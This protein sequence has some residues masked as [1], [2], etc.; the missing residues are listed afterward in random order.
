MSEEL[1]GVDVIVA[2]R[3]RTRNTF[4]PSVTRLNNGELICVF[5]YSPGHVHPRG[6]IALVR[7]DDDG[8][9]WTLPEIIIDTPYDDRDPHIVQLKDGRIILSWFTTYHATEARNSKCFVA[10]SSDYGR[11]WS[12]PIPV[13][14][15][16][17][18]TSEK[19]LELSD[20]TLL[21]PLYDWKDSVL[22]QSRD[23]GEHWERVASISNGEKMKTGVTF[24][25]TALAALGEGHI[26]AVMRTAGGDGYA[27]ITHSYDHGRTWEQPVA[28][29]VKA[30]APDM[31]VMDQGVFL[32][33]GSIAYPGRWVV[34]MFG[35]P[36]K[37]F[38]NAKEQVIY[39][40]ATKVA[41]MS[42]P[43]AVQIGDNTLF[44]VFYDAALGY[45][46]GRYVTLKDGCLS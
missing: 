8:N 46:G 13:S 5:Y 4:F 25:E 19:V 14:S 36:R 24:N 23:G 31:L 27:Y 22:F 3:T 12:R 39:A 10:T 41:D 16:S 38:A 6:A 9:S 30:H 43:A 2:G 28:L 32:C 20:G 7:S 11:T 37:N 33:Y 35:D 15:E 40:G 1:R 44:V 34:G 45:I 42:Y 26:V 18:A 17:F 29:G 21:L